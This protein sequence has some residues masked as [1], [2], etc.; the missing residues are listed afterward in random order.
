[1]IIENQW[2]YIEVDEDDIDEHQFKEEDYDGHDNDEIE[3]IKEE[4]D[5]SN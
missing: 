4:D 2:I 3:E 5:N 1:M